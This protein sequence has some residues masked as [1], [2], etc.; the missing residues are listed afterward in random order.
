MIFF[1]LILAFIICSGLTAKGK[2]EFFSDY[3]SPK[4]TSTINAI[5]SV[6]IFLSH[7]T[8]YITLNGTFDAPY[9]SMRKF[10]GQLVVVTYLF[11]SGY[12]IME[13]IKKKGTPYVKAMPKQ[14]LL[15][16]WLHFAVVIAIFGIVQIG[17]CSKSYD[18]KHILLSLTGYTS[19][20]NSNWYMF[21]TFAMYIVVIVAFLMF[22]KNNVLAVAGVWVLSFLLIAWEVKMGLATTFYNTLL[23]FP[24]GMTFSLIKPFIDKITM[25]ND[26][27]WFACMAISVY[28]FLYFSQ[29]RN[30]SEIYYVLF[31]FTA[32][33]VVLMLTMK[34]N[35]SHS[36]LDWFGE[37]IFSFFI[38]QRI[39]MILLRDFGYAKN[40]YVFVVL[41]FFATV[42]LSML[43]DTAM[44][45]LDRKAFKK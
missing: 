25:K 36:V 14:R 37:H 10:L 5:F 27:T 7:S 17:V 16:T 4:N 3:C 35:V 42:L 15:K 12:G 32:M 29:N 9:L 44:K 34:V 23:C 11:Y 38:L 43:F 45:K 20:G 18:I 1:V 33:A 40:S 2:N 22:K 39:P 41:S 31:T 24:L 30:H 26:L 13:S 6:L 8:Q 21:V 19:L 28:G